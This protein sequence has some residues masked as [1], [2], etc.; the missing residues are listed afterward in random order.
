MKKITLEIEIDAHI[1]AGLDNIQF[2]AQVSGRDD[3]WEAR[4]WV[5]ELLTQYEEK[6]DEKATS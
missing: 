1:A 2:R 6:R 3:V 5:R 4:R